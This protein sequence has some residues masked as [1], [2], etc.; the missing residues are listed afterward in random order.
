MVI[1]YTEPVDPILTRPQDSFTLMDSRL[2]KIMSQK[3]ENLLDGNFSR[4][5]TQQKL[6]ISFGDKNVTIGC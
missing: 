6:L 4:L 2:G 1:G 3:K 5:E